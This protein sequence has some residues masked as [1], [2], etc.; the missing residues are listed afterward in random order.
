LLVQGFSSART[1]SRREPAALRVAGRAVWWAP[2]AA[3]PVL[4]RVGLP[5]GRLVRLVVV[6][7]LGAPAAAACLVPPRAGVLPPGVLFLAVVVDA[8]AADFFAG[9]FLA[10]FLAAVFVAPA[11][12]AAVL[13]A[14]ALLAAAFLPGAFLPGVWAVLFL[15][16]VFFVAVVFVA[17]A[18]F[19]AAFLAAAFPA[20]ALA[21]LF[22]VDFLAAAGFFTVVCA[23]DAFLAAVLFAGAFG[24]AR[25]L[26]VGCGVITTTWCGED[27]PP[28]CT[29]QQLAPKFS[30]KRAYRQGTRHSDDIWRPQLGCEALGG[31][32][33]LRYAVQ[34]ADGAE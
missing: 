21:V 17:V 25:P 5:A 3:R 8:L 24:I 2:F 23:A 34:G 1:A 29:L 7:R 31:S 13:V 14:L 18:F 19:A 16:G 30:N 6:A 11:F 32:S 12:F 26:H 9:V 28:L 20:D 33:R 27:M 10:V 15:V 4:A 22:A